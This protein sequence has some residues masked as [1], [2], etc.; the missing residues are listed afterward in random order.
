MYIK[1]FYD[2]EA[3]DVMSSGETDTPAVESAPS[4]TMSIAALM[5]RE[6]VKSD[7][8]GTEL[9]PV[10]VNRDGSWESDSGKAESPVVPTKDE[11]KSEA[12]SESSK[13]AE[14]EAEVPEPQKE[15]VSNAKDS[16]QST[17]KSQQPEDVLKAL[18]FDDKTVSFIKELKDVDPKMVNFLNTW[19]EK[20]NVTDYLN[21]LAKD[22]SQMPAEDVMRHQLREEYPKASE[23]QLDVLYKKEIAEKYNLNSYDEDEV[24]EGKLLLDAKADKYRDT[25]VQAQKDRLLPEPKENESAKFEEQRRTKVAQ[26]IVREFNDNPY[27]KEVIAKNSITIGE[28]ADKFSFPIDSKAV[29]DLVINGDANGELMFDKKTNANGEEVYIP[30]AQH[31]LLVATVNKYGD[32]FITELAKH[33]KSLGGKAAI[34]P[35]DNARPVETRNTSNA[36]PEPTSIVGAMAKYGKLNSGGW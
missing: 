7:S 12:V 25:L 19:K 6:G 34:E 11:A 31:Q 29:T 15:E 36:S 9:N 20:G 2:M 8:E 30:K 17:I 1:K 26:G 23:A 18:G 16:W 3:S 32:K 24:A 10:R 27:T 21:E 14:P 33:Y 22:Y 4:E 28:G 13:P 5:A 35:I